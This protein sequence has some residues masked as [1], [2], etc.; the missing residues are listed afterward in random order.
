MCIR[1]RNRIASTGRRELQR[2]VP[3]T[4]PSHSGERWRRQ[5]KERA[6]PKR[7]NARACRPPASALPA[8][9]GPPARTSRPRRQRHPHH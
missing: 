8:P 9:V 6:P 7:R 4:G 3:D 1:D 2:A 5:P